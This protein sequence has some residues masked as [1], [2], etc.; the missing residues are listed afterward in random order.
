MTNKRESCLDCIY[1]Y[2][3]ITKVPAKPWEKHSIKYQLLIVSY[4]VDAKDSI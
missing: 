2:T 1:I 4:L 3:K